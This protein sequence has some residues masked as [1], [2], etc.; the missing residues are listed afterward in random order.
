MKR[1]FNLVIMAIISIIL[2]SCSVGYATTSVYS[3][4]NAEVVVEYGTPYYNESNVVV[5]YTYEGWYCYPYYYNNVRRFHYYRK[6]HH[7]YNNIYYR[8]Y[9][10]YRNR[11]IRNHFQHNHNSYRPN[12]GFG[13]SRSINSCGNRN[14]YGNH[15]RSF[16]HI[17]RR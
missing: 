15:E 13:R 8:G 12:N 1:I 14:R 9:P 4:P 5:F 11:P 2:T 10:Y 7:P 3:E 16:G 17:G 6:P